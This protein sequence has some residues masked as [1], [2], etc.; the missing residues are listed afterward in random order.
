MSSILIKEHNKGFLNILHMTLGK[1]LGDIMWPE[2]GCYSSYI[3]MDLC[4]PLQQS[5][6]RHGPGFYYYT[7]FYDLDFNFC[8]TYEILLTNKSFCS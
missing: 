1:K 8:C 6:C 3:P 4:H 7:N 5:G 2:A